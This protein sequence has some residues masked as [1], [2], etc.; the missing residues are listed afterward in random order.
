MSSSWSSPARSSATRARSWRPP[1]RS[2]R[3]GSGRGSGSCNRRRRDRR[4]AARSPSSGRER[5]LGQMPRETANPAGI[6]ARR[7]APDIVFLDQRP[8]GATQRQMERR[9]AAVE[10][11]PHDDGIMRSVI[12]APPPGFGLRLGHAG[13]LR[14]RD[15][16]DRRAQ[17]VIADLRRGLSRA[18]AISS[19]TVRPQSRPW[20]GPMPQR[21]K[22]FI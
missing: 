22:A 16:L 21:R 15:R 9:R 7:M 10:P 3:P 4:C 12:R 11:P 5:D 8:A 17:A 14:E 20:H 6:H 2:P 18:C 1:P 13:E 19:V